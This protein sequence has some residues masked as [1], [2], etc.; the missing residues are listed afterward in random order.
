MK[1]YLRDIFWLHAAQHNFQFKMV[2]NI[3]E[4]EKIVSD[5]A[6]RPHLVLLDIGLPLR[7]GGEVDKEAGF[8]FVERLRKDPET[9]DLKIIIFSSHG[10]KE[11]QER[12]IQAGADQFLVKGD[13][14]PTE[15]I[16][17][18][19]DILLRK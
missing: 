10:D 15:I 6:S 19:N 8:K 13:Q 12:A 5:P 11:I 2:D 7:R 1:M 9:K 16:R 18:A 14:I 4:A 3:E 17:V